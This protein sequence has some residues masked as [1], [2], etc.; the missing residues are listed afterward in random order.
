MAPRTDAPTATAATSPRVV[1]DPRA[2]RELLDAARARGGRVGFVPTMGALH[3]GHLALM[4]EARRR[5]ASDPAAANTADLV[6]ASV[7]VNPTQFG[8]N[9]DFGRYPRE[10][11]ADVA[12]CASAG[13]DVVFAPEPAVMY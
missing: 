11:D 5:I 12:R 1:T 4:R 2:L 3:D 8:P 6:L 13:V 7:F 10:L 9:E